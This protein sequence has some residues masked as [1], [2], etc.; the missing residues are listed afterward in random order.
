MPLLTENENSSS[1]AK[2]SVFQQPARQSQTRVLAKSSSFCD[3][4]LLLVP[5]PDG[6]RDPNKPVF[7]RH[8]GQTG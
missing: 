1:A 7:S 5:S 2:N 6:M 4:L 8:Q 3:F